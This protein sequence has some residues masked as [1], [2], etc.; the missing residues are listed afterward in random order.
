MENV[1]NLDQPTILYNQIEIMK[2]SI[3]DY[4]KNIDKL[5]DSIKASE[6][7]LW[8]LCSHEWEYDSSCNFDDR[9]K[10]FCKKCK[11]W[12]NEYMYT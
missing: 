2:S 8:K 10:Y 7:K 3:Y 12:R 9:T 5:K 1:L 6:K 4:E 11:L